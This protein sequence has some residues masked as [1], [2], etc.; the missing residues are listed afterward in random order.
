M[1]TLSVTATGLGRK[2]SVLSCSQHLPRTRQRRK[3]KGRRGKR[4]KR[5]GRVRSWR[6]CGATLQPPPPSPSPRLPVILPFPTAWSTPV[7]RTR[8]TNMAS[9]STESE[10]KYTPTPLPCTGYKTRDP[11]VWS[12]AP[13]SPV[14]GLVRNTASASTRC[15]SFPPPSLV[16]STTMNNVFTK[17]AGHCHLHYSPPP[18]PPQLC[19]CAKLR[20]STYIFC[21]MIHM[22]YTL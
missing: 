12:A 11:H 1:E 18:P 13:P 9:M 19:N 4:L 3:G 17:K 14:P 22:F 7:P 10:S 5:R 21:K 2:K 16:S 6:K 20:N 8:P 15:E